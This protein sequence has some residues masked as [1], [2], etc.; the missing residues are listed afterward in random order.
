MPGAG[1]QRRV[2]LALTDPHGHRGAAGV[3][4]QHPTQQNVGVPVRLDVT[5]AGSQAQHGLDPDPQRD[6][7]KRDRFR[8]RAQVLG[9]AVPI[10]MPLVGR[11]LSDADGIQ[12][13]QRRRGIEARVGGLCENTEAV[14]CKPDDKLRRSQSTRRQERE[15]RGSPRG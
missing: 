13:E 2:A 12:R 7:R 8:Q 11:A 9:L 1:Q 10:L 6:G 4:R 15:E 5:A 3:D 14:G